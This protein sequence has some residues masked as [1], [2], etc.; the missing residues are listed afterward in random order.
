MQEFNRYL[1]ISSRY[2]KGVST[3]K[4]GK[5]IKNLLKF[6]NFE[7]LKSFGPCFEAIV[8]P[9][10][11]GEDSEDFSAYPSL[12]KVASRIIDT[13][14]IVFTDRF[15]KT[16]HGPCILISPISQF[17]KDSELFGML[18]KTGVFVQSVQVIDL[19]TQYGKAA[20]L[21]FQSEE[22]A[23]DAFEKFFKGDFKVSEGLGRIANVKWVDYKVVYPSVQFF[24]VVVRGFNKKNTPGE[25][26]RV[27]PVRFCRCEIRVVDGYGC[28][29]FVFNTLED[30]C[31]VCVKMNGVRD[32]FG[33]L[34]KVHLHPLTQKK[35]SKDIFETLLRQ[36][37]QTQIGQ[38][39]LS[40]RL[41]LSTETKRV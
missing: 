15:G 36:F 23:Q 20:L 6:R 24:A 21:W 9:A 11:S 7:H 2:F 16:Q 28:G 37:R 14:S 10:S 18:S 5:K 39:E 34:L 17:L 26:Y 29:L 25:L 41:R 12:S 13:S 30:L 1:D 3:V 4:I 22:L 31:T 33:D 35:H 32:C 38:S 19:N 8:T 27:F 40:L